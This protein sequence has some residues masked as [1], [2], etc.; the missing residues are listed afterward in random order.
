M[1]DNQGLQFQMQILHHK[2]NDIRPISYLDNMLDILKSTGYEWLVVIYGGEPFLYPDFI[3]ICLKLTQFFKVEILTNL[4]LSNEIREFS[5]KVDPSRIIIRTSTHIEERL[6]KNNIEEYVDNILLLRKKGFSV[7][8][9]YVLHPELWSR[10][11]DDSRYFISRGIK[12][13]PTAYKGWYGMKMY[14]NAYSAKERA[15]ISENNPGLRFYPVSLK[16]I[17][18]DAG[19]RYILIDEGGTVYRCAN[20]FTVIG[21]MDDSVNFYNTS[22]P[23]KVHMCSCQGLDLI[24]NKAELVKKKYR[25]AYSYWRFLLYGT[26]ADYRIQWFHDITKF[27]RIFCY[28]VRDSRFNFIRKIRQ[29]GCGDINIRK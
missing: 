6:I 26:K 18:C 25:T 1:E 22:I 29:A 28:A 12:L 16:G 15:F 5:D 19:R 27:I 8:P 14:P 21:N 3:N 23:C 7:Y 2:K 17:E 9:G 24:G 20:D 13:Y 4:S 11:E 10:F